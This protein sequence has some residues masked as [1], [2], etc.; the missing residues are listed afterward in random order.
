MR[1]LFSILMFTFTGHVDFHLL[2]LRVKYPFYRIHFTK[3][4]LKGPI[5]KEGTDTR[6]K[7]NQEGVERR[8]EGKNQRETILL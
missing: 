7:D 2:F 5:Q 1:Y 4:I 3:S 6:G 8:E